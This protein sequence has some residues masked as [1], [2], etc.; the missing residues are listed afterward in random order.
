VLKRILMIST[1]DV[2]TV[3]VGYITLWVNGQIE[4]SVGQKKA[5]SSVSLT[6]MFVSYKNE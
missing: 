5:R 3:L 2:N 6:M 1:V 4:T